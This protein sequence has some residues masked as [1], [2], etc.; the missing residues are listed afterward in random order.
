MN[1]T[2]HK[3]ARKCI[4]CRVRFPSVSLHA[5]VAGKQYAA[6]SI[7]SSVCTCSTVFGDIRGCSRWWNLSTHPQ[8]LNKNW[9]PRLVREIP[10]SQKGI[11]DI[12]AVTSNK[13]WSILTSVQSNLAKGRIADLSPLAAAN[14]FVRSWTP[15]NTWFIGTTWVS[16]KRHLDRFSCLCRAH[17]CNKHTDRHTY[18]P[19]YVWHLS[20]IGRRTYA[21]HWCG[22]NISAKM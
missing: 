13:H 1:T 8:V 3:C 7:S 10:L 22:L 6:A 16:P 17:P 12:L 15:S 4:I 20:A 9:H 14:A 5:S 18:K 19:R 2:S 11:P 21:M